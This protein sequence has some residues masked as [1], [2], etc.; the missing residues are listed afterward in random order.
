MAGFL[1]AVILGV[2]ISWVASIVSLIECTPNPNNKLTLRGYSYV[3][4]SSPEHMA[5]VPVMIISLLAVFAILAVFCKAL[6]VAPNRFDSKDFRIRISFLTKRYRAATYWYAMVVVFRSLVFSLSTVVCASNGFE[7]V[8]MIAA[9]VVWA[10][11]MQLYFW[12][13]QDSAANLYE[14]V[15]LTGLLLILICSSFFLSDKVSDDEETTN[16]ETNLAIFMMVTFVVVLATGAAV[17]GFA[18]SLVL[19]PRKQEERRAKLAKCHLSKLQQLAADLSTMQKGTLESVLDA[20]SF[21]ER[22]NM[23][24]V[25]RF[26]ELEVSGRQP[27]KASARRL[28]QLYPP[29][30]RS[31]ETTAASVAVATGADASEAKS[32]VVH[33]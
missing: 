13:Y 29:L 10:M 20:A 32:Y 24:Q 21:M 2:F 33:V 23:S 18:S 30:P 8:D 3:E 1:G 5:M 11:M 4:C 27:S 9:I 16:L 25:I 28:P 14:V 6:W 22:W 19:S 26:F 15:Q 31:G 12:P 7:Q 17:L